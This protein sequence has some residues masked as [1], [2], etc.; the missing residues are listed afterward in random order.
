MACSASSV[1]SPGFG[2]SLVSSS[3]AALMA[4]ASR[5][6]EAD[7]VTSSYRELDAC[8]QEANTSAYC[9]AI[10]SRAEPAN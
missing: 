1:S 4:S 2:S 9:V 8:F 6:L 7:S 5:A 3:T 10:T